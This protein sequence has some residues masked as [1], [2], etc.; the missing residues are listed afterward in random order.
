[1][2]AIAGCARTD[3][4]VARQRSAENTSHAS[5]RQKAGRVASDPQDARRMASDPQ[6]ASSGSPGA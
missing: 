1:M 4:D 3:G 6:E 2:E 5:D